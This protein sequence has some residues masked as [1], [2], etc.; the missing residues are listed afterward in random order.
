M[1]GSIPEL[2]DGYL[3]IARFES[4]T[5]VLT[6]QKKLEIMSSQEEIR[7]AIR[8]TADIDFNAARTQLEI[9][10]RE[11]CVFLREKNM[12]IPSDT[13]Q[14]MLDASV[15]K[16]EQSTSESDDL[17]E[18]IAI[19]EKEMNKKIDWSNANHNIM[20]SAMQVAISSIRKNR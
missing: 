14:F 11:A 4:Y 3:K 7:K 18:A 20:V 19:F 16:I 12:T 6:S 15:E 9:E 1:S 10:V 5:L 8:E 17:K 13:I 2:I